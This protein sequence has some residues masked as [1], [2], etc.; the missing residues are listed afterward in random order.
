MSEVTVCDYLNK[1]RHVFCNE[2]KT[3]ILAH[4]HEQLVTSQHICDQTNHIKAAY[5]NNGPFF[6]LYSSS[7]KKYIIAYTV[8]LNPDNDTFRIIDSSE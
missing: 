6:S 5:G 8:L 4:I 1:N 7:T 3:K 2:F